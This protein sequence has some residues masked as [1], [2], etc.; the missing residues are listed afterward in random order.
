M[1]RTVLVFGAY[2]NTGRLV[3]AELVD[4]GLVPI[5][6]GRDQGRLDALAAS[7]SGLD[8]R[9]MSVDDTASL[10][11]AVAGAE[12]VVNCAGPF[13]TTAAPLLDAALRAG[14][15]Y[16]DVAAESKTV[17]DAFAQFDDRVRA[18]GIAVV[19]AMAFFGGFADL[20]TTAAMGNWTS[21]DEVTI[22]YGLSSWQPTTGIRA[23]VSR[24]KLPDGEP[25]KWN[26]PAP[27]GT[28]SVVDWTTADAVTI[29]SHLDVAELHTYLT[30][31]AAREVMT[32]AVVEHD[33]SEQT[34][35]VEVVVRS[36]GAERRIVASGRDMY[37]FTAPLAVEAVESIL[38]GRHRTTGVASA[39]RMFDAVEFL[40]AL[41]EHISIESKCAGRRTSGR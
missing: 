36:E 21:A 11:R 35:A 1:G 5:A 23:T 12:A 38:A 7:R 2:G 14:I 3:L 37:A 27:L 26:F 13:A 25:Q 15:P 10:D 4:R 8:T 33:M 20:L 41:S 9:R 32:S 29:P 18:A 34:F 17:A 31:E 19:P 6:T 22:A 39:G 30:V 40:Q 16:V 28:R 24:R